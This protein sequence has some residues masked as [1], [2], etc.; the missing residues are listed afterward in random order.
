[1]TSSR[2]LDIDGKPLGSGKPAF[3]IAEVGQNHDGSLGLAHCYVDAAAKAGADA[4]KFQ[5]HIASQESSREDQWRVKFSKQDDTRYAYWQRM[6]FTVEQWAGLKQHCDEAGVTFLSSAFSIAAVELL[7]KLNMAA[8][9]LGSGEFASSA[10]MDAMKATG[11][12]LLYSTGM[13][14]WAEIDAATAQF[15]SDGTGFA[16]FQCTSTYPTVLPDVGLNV[17]DAMRARYPGIPVG[18]S[19]HS[20]TVFPATAAMARDVDIVE[21]HL[22][23]DR[24]MF[25]PDVVA[26]VTT[27]ELAQIAAARDA[28]SAMDANPVDKDEMAGRLSGMRMLFT[29]SV[30]P[31]R[32]LE[33]GTVLSEDLLCAK[34]PGTGIPFEDRV[35][36]I[37]RRTNRAIAVDELISWDDLE[38]QNA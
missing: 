17:L 23:F 37:G 12:P 28:F 27:V 18:L 33:A 7:S 21:L 31:A 29:K 15:Q 8:W 32:D 13:S 30:S 4:V 5:T 9:K 35:V 3:L 34:K 36:L 25:G 19:D 26:S 16:L 24:D 1:M 20:G 6:E 11:K 14:N 22:T 10:L 38:L 2:Q